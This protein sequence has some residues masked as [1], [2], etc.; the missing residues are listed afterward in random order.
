MEN[1][2]LFLNFNLIG[3]FVPFLYSCPFVVVMFVSV[4]FR[5]SVLVLVYC[6]TSYFMVVLRS[7]YVTVQ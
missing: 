5:M 3:T 4:N 1:D 2:R 7:G 6:P